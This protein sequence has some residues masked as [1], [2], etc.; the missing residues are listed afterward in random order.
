MAEAWIFSR[1]GLTAPDGRSYSFTEIALKVN[2]DLIA[3][4]TYTDDFTRKEK[5]KPADPNYIIEK[6]ERFTPP[7]EWQAGL[8]LAVK[9]QIPIE[10]ANEILALRKIIENLKEHLAEITQK[11]NKAESELYHQ[12]EEIRW[13]EA[14]KQWEEEQKKQQ[15]EVLP[16][17]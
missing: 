5:V 16:S 12:I 9:T 1:H 17:Q 4:E 14:E 11:I 6:V 15:E 3:F 13:E 7:K 2:G 10:K 8:D